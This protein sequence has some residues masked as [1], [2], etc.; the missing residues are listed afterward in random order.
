MS[1]LV[2]GGHSIIQA[3]CLVNFHLLTLVEIF[4]ISW[5]E[6]CANNVKVTW[7]SSKH[8]SKHV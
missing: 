6:R 2:V 1:I 3:L 7:H 5:L 8:C 4:K